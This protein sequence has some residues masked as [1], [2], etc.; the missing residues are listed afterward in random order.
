M[1][2]HSP[3]PGI[4]ASGI[5]A[6]AVPPVHDLKLLSAAEARDVR[7]RVHALRQQWRRRREEA[8]FYTLGVAGYIDAARDGF[9]AYC[10]AARD[11]NALLAEH[12]GDLYARLAAAIGEHLSEPVAY[13][14]G[15]ALPGFHIFLADP[16]FATPSASLHFDRQYEHL[17]WSGLDAAD[18]D[19]QLSY[20]LSIALPARGAGLLVWR[21][22]DLELRGLPEE[23][24]KEVMRQN[25]RPVLHPYR[26]GG[27]AVHSG[28][29]LHQIAPMKDMAPDD[30]RITLQGHALPAGGRWVLYW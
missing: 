9:A 3:A 26:V 30:E 14:D 18:F 1:S 24:R 13:H 10:A 7:A 21:V 2:V 19:R 4:P 22:N 17:D 6:A 20:T 28:H 29:Q 8:P 23:N 11:S 25:R 27:L 12:F 16:Q 5:P 15:F